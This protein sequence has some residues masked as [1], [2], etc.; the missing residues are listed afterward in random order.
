MRALFSGSFDP[1]TNGHLDLIGRVAPLV[2]MLIVAVAINTE[3][4]PLFSEEER[5]AL[6][7]DACRAWPNV[8]V[9]RNCGL[10]VEAARVFAADVIIRGFRNVLEGERELEMARVNRQLSGIETLL[11]PASPQWATSSSSLVKEIARFGGDVSSLVPGAVAERLQALAAAR[12]PGE[13]D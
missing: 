10:T 8:R 3:K 12:R 7:R 6:L 13:A 5:M 2:E 9:E 1:V 11:L 4:R